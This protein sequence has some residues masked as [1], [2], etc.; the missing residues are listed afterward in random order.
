MPIFPGKPNMLA[1]SSTEVAHCSALDNRQV[2]PLKRIGV[3]FVITAKIIIVTKI[4]VLVT[5]F[6]ITRKEAA[7]LFNNER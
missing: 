7:T 1:S 5:I 3:T 4:H 2:L 6:P